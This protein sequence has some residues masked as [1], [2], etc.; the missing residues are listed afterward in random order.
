MKTSDPIDELLEKLCQGDVAAAQQVFLTYESCLRQVVRRHLPLQLRAK[1]DSVDVVQS[2]WAD[3][4]HRFRE[5]HWRFADANHLRSF[6]IKV[7]RHR[8]ID[9]YRQL[10][11]SLAKEQPMASESGV[12]GATARQPSPS[13]E[14]QA[15]ELWQQMLALSPPGHHELLR[16]K[17]QGL[18]VPE[19]A[20]RTGMH[21]DSIRRVLRNLARQLALSSNAPPTSR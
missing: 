11:M 1:F 13:E 10:H 3:L 9:R 18:P 17:R 15:D 14:V 16:L 19:I 20:A 7:T 5:D 12:A 6:L 21:E 8:L 2:I 4:V